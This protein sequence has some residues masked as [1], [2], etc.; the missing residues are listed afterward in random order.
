MTWLKAKTAI[1]VGSAALLVA[2]AGAAITHHGH[3]MSDPN[4]AQEHQNK[5]AAER[6]GGSANV[7]QDP[8]AE[9]LEDEQKALRRQ[10][11]QSR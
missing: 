3:T 4:E 9:K 5:L 11:T 2:G 7:T 10:Q 6:A 8:N 1:L